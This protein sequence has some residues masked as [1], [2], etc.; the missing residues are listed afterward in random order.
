LLTR[1]GGPLNLKSWTPMR[2]ISEYSKPFRFKELCH[3]FGE[4]RRRADAGINILLLF[5]YI[6]SAFCEIYV[7]R[8][9][10]I[11]V[12][13]VADGLECMRSLSF[14]GNL[15][16]RHNFLVPAL[17]I[18][19][20]KNSDGPCANNEYACVQQLA[21]SHLP[22]FRLRLPPRPKFLC[23]HG[24]NCIVGAHFAPINSDFLAAPCTER[25]VKMPILC[26][27]DLSTG[28]CKC[29]QQ[30]VETAVSRRRYVH[31]VLR[32]FFV[33]Y[34]FIMICGYKQSLLGSIAIPSR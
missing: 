3:I 29:E 24:V 5:I 33:H 34:L 7:M 25:F 9:D 2:S 1:S 21:F 32:I 18:C 11:R 19:D 6:Y 26:F 13:L 22:D 12:Y 14:F 23:F 16:D 31:E 30:S 28:N 20:K 17:T 4:C 27:D 15:D 10:P 8:H